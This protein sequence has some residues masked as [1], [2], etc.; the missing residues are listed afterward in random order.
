MSNYHG[1]KVEGINLMLHYLIDIIQKTLKSWHLEKLQIIQKINKLMF[2]VIFLS[3]DRILVKQI[4]VSSIPL[5]LGETDFQ[6]ILSNFS[7][8][9]WTGTWAKMDRFIGFSRN[10]NTINWKIFPT[11][12]FSTQTFSHAIFPTQ[13]R[14]NSTSILERHKT[15]TS[16]K[17][18]ERMYPWS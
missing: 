6:K 18:Y 15:L 13:V 2:Q 14:E 8:E 7:F 16:L 11:H 3:F 12:V 4:I 5:F 1:C 9:W 17:K 10:V